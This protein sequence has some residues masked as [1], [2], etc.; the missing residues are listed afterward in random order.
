M[1]TTQSER[2]GLPHGKT[3]EWRP[4][5]GREVERWREEKR[6]QLEL[7][8]KVGERRRSKPDSLR[9]KRGKEV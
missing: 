4:Q 5:Q 7:V 2:L 9:D 1:K 3:K 8:T 6:E